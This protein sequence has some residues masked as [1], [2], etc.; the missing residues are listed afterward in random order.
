MGSSHQQLNEKIERFEENDLWGKV[1]L[2]IGIQAFLSYNFFE[3]FEKKLNKQLD[4][5]LQ[6]L[7]RN[8]KESDKT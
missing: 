8:L 6:D 3:R 5:S 1:K 2:S 4:F 7:M